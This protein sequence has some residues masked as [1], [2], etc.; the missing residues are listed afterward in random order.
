M[1]SRQRNPIFCIKGTGTEYIPL[2]FLLVTHTSTY[3]TNFNFTI[4]S[5]PSLRSGFEWPPLESEDEPAKSEAAVASK[6]V[7]FHRS[8]ST[9]HNPNMTFARSQSVM[10]E[11]P[12][13]SLASNPKIETPRPKFS[14]SV[15]CVE[16][17]SIN[18]RL[19]SIDEIIYV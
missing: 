12:S 11:I 18:P 9:L 2:D 19:N 14:R 16:A 13:A 7:S 8:G 17:A 1:A 4:P 10:I 3:R 6:R 5:P 15:S